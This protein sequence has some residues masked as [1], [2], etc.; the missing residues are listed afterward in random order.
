MADGFFPTLVSKDANANSLTN[1][2]FVQITDGTDGL[3]IN[4]DG[5]LN[6]TVTAANLD[7]RDLVF[8]TD[9]VDVTGS[10]VTVTATNLDIRD[11]VFATDKVDI[12]GSTLGANSGVDIGDV[13]INNAGGASAVNIQDGGNSIT[14][15]GS[16]SIT[17]SVAVTSTDLDIRDLTLA[18]DAVRISANTSANS[19]VN[20]I[21]VSFTSTAVT[22]EVHD[23]NTATVSGGSTSNHDY[24]VVTAMLVKGI[25]F[26]ASGAGKVELKTGPLASLVSKWVG[27]IPKQGGTVSVKFDPAIEVP[28]TSTGTVRLI[29][30]NR[31]GSSQDLYSTIIGIDA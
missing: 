31:E 9:K 10:S 5:S 19:A 2:I 22:G 21:Y 20:P 17:G 1:Q 23:Y 7:I 25:E 27:F 28:V 11:L 26:S 18:Q 4:G 8:A 24:T 14:V 29:R 16:V 3:L 12:S 30:T 6:A 15:D 13:T